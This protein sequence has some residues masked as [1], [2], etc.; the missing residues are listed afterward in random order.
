MPMDNP[1]EEQSRPEATK[2]TS[3]AASAP[4]PPAAVPEPKPHIGPLMMTAIP[5]G[6]ETALPGPLEEKHFPGEI[7]GNFDE[8]LKTV[9]PD[10]PESRPGGGRRSFCRSILRS[11]AELTR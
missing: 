7:G 8:A 1:A 2:A 4:A 3:D 5:G 11:L 6:G 9:A 10:G